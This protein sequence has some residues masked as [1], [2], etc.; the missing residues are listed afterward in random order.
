[1]LRLIRNLVIILIVVI[2]LA[3]CYYNYNPVRVDLIWTVTDAALSTILGAAFVL[4][5]VIAFLLC[6]GR[7]FSL[8]RKLSR[9]RK[10]LKKA[11]NE[12]S[13]W[14]ETPVKNK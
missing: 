2:A 6:G 1:M 13:N 5:L 8:R 7:M 11:E 12:L 4:G 3:F 14:R 9:A 10:E